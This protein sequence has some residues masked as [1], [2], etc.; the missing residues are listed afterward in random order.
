MANNAVGDQWGRR[1]A[2]RYGSRPGK[3]V[4]PA[5]DTTRGED[6]P[7]TSCIGCQSPKRE[8]GER[9]RPRY[10][11]VQGAGGCRSRKTTPALAP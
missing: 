2:E 6:G 9:C 7:L 3:L 4:R 5:L 11:A 10:E 1:G 8:R